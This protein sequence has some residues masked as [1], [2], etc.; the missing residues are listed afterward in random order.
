[1]A[2]PPFAR[3][4]VS[5]RGLAFSYGANRIFENLNLELG[6]ENPVVFLGPSGCGKT[7]LLLLIAGLLK[8]SAGSLVIGPGALAQGASAPPAG[9]AAAGFPPAAFVFQEPR[10][11]PWKTVIENVALPPLQRLM[12]KK[13][14][15]E[16]A[17]FILELAGL[18]DKLHSRPAELSGGQ[19]QRVN[20]ARAFAFP[21]PVILLDEPFQSLD[22]PLKI[23]MM[24]LVQT[25]LD[26]EEGRRL[27]VVVTHD[28][29]EAAYLGRRIMVL[30][31]PGGGEKKNPDP[32]AAVVFDEALDPGDHSYGSPAQAALERRLLAALGLHDRLEHE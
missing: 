27:A 5:I 26:R 25:L 30:G 19:R 29:R 11:F 18:K 21:S 14:A 23:L 13:E 32:S 10:L 17:R 1:L 16:R 15:G 4:G 31:R 9:P 6:E 24:D 7:T 12:G 28:P 22:I 2:V 8:P 3:P 20:L